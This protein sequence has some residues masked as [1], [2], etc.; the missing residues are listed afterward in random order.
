MH[1]KQRITGMS[2]AVFVLCKRESLGSAAVV[3]ENGNGVV[4]NENANEKSLNAEPFHGFHESSP[5][6]VVFLALRNDML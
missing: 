2:C 5:F 1:K 6:K 4:D 3:G